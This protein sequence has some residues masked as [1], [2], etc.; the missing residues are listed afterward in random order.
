MMPGNVLSTVT[1]QGLFEPPRDGVKEA[2]VDFEIGG[3]AI[4]DVSQGLEVKVWRAF[5]EVGDALIKLEAD[6]VPAFVVLADAD[7]TEV[8]LAFDQL[9]RP[10]IAYVA[11]GQAKLYWWDT[12]VEAF[13][14]T[15]LPGGAQNPRVCLD[16]KRPSQS[17]NS[18]V[19]LAYVSGGKLWMRM[20]RDRYTVDYELS[21][22]G[23]AALLQIGRNRV[24]RF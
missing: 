6:S 15:N 8:S 24:G 2:A 23:G 12:T 17:S 18:D 10:S 5:V 11:G 19:L 16:D 20:Q 22:V 14:T 1:V 3:V 7:I 9:M 13:V 21:D 4:G